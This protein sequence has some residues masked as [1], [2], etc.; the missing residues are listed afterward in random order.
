[1]RLAPNLLTM[2]SLTLLST[3]SFAQPTLP[4]SHG[5]KPPKL[6]GMEYPKARKIILGYG[7]VLSPGNC[8]GIDRNY[9]N[10]CARFP[11]IENCSGTG[12]GYCDMDFAKPGQCLTVTTV[13]GPPGNAGKG[14]ETIVDEIYFSRHRCLT[15]T[16]RN[17]PHPLGWHPAP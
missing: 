12:V 17:S 10:S 16:E 7:W 13:G 14:E 9:D 11:E 4:A 15:T 5:A 6:E 1:M 8:T 3:Q 2:I